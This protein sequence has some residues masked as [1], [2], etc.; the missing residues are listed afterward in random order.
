MSG[1]YDDIISLSRPISQNRRRMSNEERA[2]QF[3]PFAALK[4]YEDMIEDASHEKE[5]FALSEERAVELDETLQRI[6]AAKQSLYLSVTYFQRQHG[7]KF[8]HIAVKNGTMI[9]FDPNKKI[10]I[11]DDRKIPCSDL[12]SLE[13]INRNNLG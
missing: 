4:G 1:I 7:S 8:G 9:K 3:S 2:A 10:L 12:I 5:T 13:V 11:F 6:L